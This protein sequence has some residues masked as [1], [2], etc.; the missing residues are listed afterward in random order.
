C[1]QQA[2]ALHQEFGDH[3]GEAHTWDSL[4]FTH[5][6]LGNHRLAVTCYQHA[7]DLHLGFGD[8]YHE[9]E[10]LIRLGDTYDA[11]GD[12]AAARTAWHHALNILSELGHADTDGVRVKLRDLAR[13]G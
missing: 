10:T 12:L 1:C 6:H 2:L 4:G 7:L 9:A 11:M 13:T 5:H 8:R 3:P